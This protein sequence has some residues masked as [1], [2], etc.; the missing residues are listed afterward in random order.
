MMRPTALVHRTLEILARAPE[1]DPDTALK[2]AA[3]EI[4]HAPAARRLAEAVL[5]AIL[6]P[7][8]ETQG[9]A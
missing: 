1:M 5:L 7:P 9:T 8:R 6:T 2:L 3:A 4:P